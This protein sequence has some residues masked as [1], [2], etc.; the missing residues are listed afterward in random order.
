MLPNQWHEGLAVRVDWTIGHYTVPWTQ[1]EHLS[2]DEQGRYWS[3]RTL[4]QT[5]PV[6]RYDSPSSLQV[7]F[8]PDD[9]L[10][11]WATK[12]DLGHPDHPSKRSYPK[13][14]AELAAVPTPSRSNPAPGKDTP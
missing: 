3:E 7:F 9:K 4:Q 5:V 14:P 11:V 10:E 8:L 1:R 2:F 12:Y 13:Q 6:Q